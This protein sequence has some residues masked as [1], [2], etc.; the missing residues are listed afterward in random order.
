MNKLKSFWKNPT[1]TFEY[2]LNEKISWF[3]TTLFFGCNGIIFIYTILKAKGLINVET[4]AN[5]MGTILTMLSIGLIYGII[6]NF[7][8]GYAIKL[9]GKLF[10]AKNDLK[11]IYKALS[12]ASFPESL[13]VY[14]LIVS[15]LMVRIITTNEN[16][17]LIL[18]LSML[19]IIFMFVF[20]V[21]SIWRI[22]LVF[23]GLKV[24]QGLNTRD[25]IL[26]YIAGALIFG[27]INYFLIKPYLYG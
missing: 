13:T 18:T 17:P 3:K 20:A 22:V 2:V 5:T 8:I 1:T 11:Q 16:V 6:A 4:F 23:K 15:I 26:N 12:W 14:L 27:V 21:V 24:A 9:T 19:V 10:N 7:F 25:T